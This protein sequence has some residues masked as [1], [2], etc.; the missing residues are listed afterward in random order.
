M[1]PGVVRI[2]AVRPAL[3]WPTR[4]LESL[5]WYA[6]LARPGTEFAVEALLE[7]RGFVAIVPL[8]TEYRHVNRYVRRKVKRTYV[9]APRYVLVGFGAH[10]L[11]NGIPPWNE[12]FSITMV[13][14]VV[15]LDG[16]P[17]RMRGKAVAAFIRAHGLYEAPEEQQH[18]RT[19]REFKVGDT[20]E[21]VEGSLAGMRVQ[22][23]AI[24]G[25]AARVLLPLFGKKEQE[26]ALRLSD[27]EPVN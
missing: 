22:V 5:N 26:F 9:L 23:H 11:R 19:H 16:E 4:M 17:W 20:V 27:L 6:V 15:G 3:L 24:D 7:R 8:H 2:A 14:A 1:V 10:Q 13:H 21:V 12:V 18:M 25:A